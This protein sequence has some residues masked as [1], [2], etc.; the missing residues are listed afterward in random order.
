VGIQWTGLESFRA[1][2]RKLPEHLAEEAGVIVLAHAAE[3]ERL[4]ETAYPTGPTGNLKRGV[5]LTTESTRLAAVGTVKSTAPHA[6]L[7]ERGTQRRQT[8]KGANRGVM[9]VAPHSQQMIPII[10]SV[11]RR[12]V[13]ALMTLVERAGFT[14]VPTS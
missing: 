11:R 4:V 9:P 2:L 1:E 12:M 10:V 8:K 5:K 3:A 13:M 6:H 7:F 14:I